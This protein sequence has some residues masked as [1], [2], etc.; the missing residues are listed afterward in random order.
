[1]RAKILRLTRWIIIGLT[2]LFAMLLL[3]VWFYTQ[4]EGFR[5]LLREQVL[6][7]LR[8]S[9][10]GEVTFEEASGSVWRQLHFRRLSVRQNGVEVLSAPEISVRISL[11]RQ[12]FAFLLS[13]RFY[14]AEVEIVEPKVKLIEDKEKG[15]NIASLFKTS[16]QPQEPSAV[17][18]FLSHIKIEKGQIDA[19][20]AD[21]SEAHLMALSLDGSLKL[22]PAGPQVDLA[23]LDFSLSRQGLPELQ[24]KSALSYDATGAPSVLN[25][26]RIDLQTSGSQLRLS[27][28]VQDLSAPTLALNLELKKI[29]ANEIRKLLPSLPLQQDLSGALH[30]T[31]PLSAFQLAGNISAPDGQLIPSVLGDLTQKQPRFRG[32]LQVKDFVADRVLGISNL[33]GKWNGQASFQGTSLEDAQGSVRAS[34]S[35]LL[36][37]G[38]QMGD[39]GL[40]GNLAN[41]KVALTADVTGKNGQA[42]LQG[43]MVLSETPA[44]EMTLKARNLELAKAR[45]K[46]SP[47]SDSA[48]INLDAW[49]KGRG[50]S[51]KKIDSSA[52]LTLLPSKIGSI[53]IS[54][55][56]GT[57]ALRQGRLTLQEFRLLA[58]DAS[59]TA[60]GELGAL[61]EGPKGKMIYTL[62]ANNLT[63][64]LALAGLKGRGGVNLDGTASG[65][66]KSLRLEGKANLSNLQLA[67]YS[68]QSGSVSWTLAEVGGPQPHGQIKVA[69]K[70]VEAGMRLQRLEADLSLK[71]MEPMEVQT[72]LVAEDS[73][74]HVHRLKGRGNY[75]SPEQIDFLVQELALHLSNGIW[76]TPQQAHLVWRDKRIS[77]DDLSL[78]RGAQ[79]VRA[80]GVLGSQGEQDLYLQ[81]SRF[82]LEELRP[83][84]RRAPDVT[85]QLSAEIKVRGTATRPL[86]D[87]NLAVDSLTVAGQSY[88]GLTANAAYGQERLNV[89]LLLRQDVSH[90]LNAKGGLPLY[91]GW[92]GEKSPAV[93]GEASLRI[94]S[95]GLSPAFLAVLSKEIQ[96]IQGNLSMDIQLRGPAQA[97]LPTGKIQLRGGQAK[98]KPLG[99]SLSDVELL[100]AVAQNALDITQLRVRSGEGQLTGGGKIGLKE[101]S[102]TGLDLTFNANE[103]SVINT[104]QYKAA[105]S[106]KLVSSGSLEKPF[107]RGEL[108]LTKSSLRPDRSLLQRRGPPPRD[109]TVLVVQNAEELTAGRQQEKK[110]EEASGQ[111]SEDSSPPQSD[112]YRRLGLD[113]A[114][115]I[116]RGTWV[117][118]EE[119]SIEL[120]GQV[121]A[122]KNPEEELSLSGGVET[123]RGSY[124]FQGRKFQLERGKVLFTGGS[125]IDPSLDVA[126]RYALPNYQVDLVVGGASSAPTLTLRSEPQLEQADILSLLL[127][128][129]RA[130]A[131]NE[132]ERVSFQAQAIKAAADYVAGGLQQSVAEHLGL[133]VVEL[134]VGEGLGQGKV[135]VGKNVTKDVFVSASQELDKEKAQEYSIEYQLAP[136]WQLKSSTT[137]KGN[138]GFDLFWQKQY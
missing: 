18:I 111:S 19:R 54:Q 102:I 47:V 49:V 37:Q 28:K 2:S 32:T 126:A 4:T 99:L 20:L 135:G 94:Y 35:G 129:K 108:N 43:R 36:V 97:L 29:A 78:Q 86:L 112:L 93:S 124:T 76:R 65:S 103:F 40:E 39:L 127:F 60:R 27:G 45:E 17:S 14:I 23:S 115:T 59:L 70:G 62:R 119:G 15:W 122:R 117:Y 123:V 130:G 131:L 125:K 79:T 132:G 6:A 66:I 12:V 72:A 8:S 73:E 3:G 87:G 24:W 57:G 109:P 31:G 55:G 58:N 136:N 105:V 95:A 114:A 106:G 33:S 25:L 68:L 121:R 61:E 38:W 13:S 51:L 9:V 67:A 11:L 41:K 128:G 80:R 120:M 5:S 98:V 46:G 83:F 133:D 88:A 34:A 137:S 75:Y 89:D 26:R 77:V 107:V 48:N 116:P 74:K 96:D 16:D 138:N 71:G 69:T 63:P 30:V 44:Y 53:Q 42:R 82:P 91:I 64:W 110:S 50:I 134:N 22:V 21:E 81:V 10:N 90:S 56:R 113:V 104:R 84:L 85:G 92:G 100:V 101:Y 1:M 118:L 52:E 7:A